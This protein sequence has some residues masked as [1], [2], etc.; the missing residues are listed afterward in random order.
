MR[1]WITSAAEIKPC[2]FRGKRDVSGVGLFCSLQCVICV[3]I[4]IFQLELIHR[5]WLKRKLCIQ[6]LPY[7][8]KSLSACLLY[9]GCWLPWIDF[10]YQISTVRTAR[11]AGA[12]F[13]T[14]WDWEADCC[15]SECRFSCCFFSLTWIFHI[16]KRKRLLSDIMEPLTS[17]NN[18]DRVSSWSWSSPGAS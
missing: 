7:G 12:Q 6:E 3:K 4:E 13:C 5:T 9:C 8:R 11:E 2:I 16:I 15:L 14:W 1:W 18:A 10:G 17:I